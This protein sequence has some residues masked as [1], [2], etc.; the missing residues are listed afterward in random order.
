[1]AK[2]LDDALI[3]WEMNGE[4]LPADHG[5]PARLVVPGWVGIASIKWLGE[6]RVTTTRMRP[7][8][9]RKNGIPY[10]GNATMNEYFVR[11]VDDEGQQYLAVT[12]M[13]DDP[14]YFLQPIVRTMLFK[15]QPDAT[16]WNPTPCVA[17]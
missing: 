12:Q 10:S 6:L 4:P 11:I 8:Y 7:G 5:F 16:G 9:L 15:K 1:M 14:Q 2:A 3:A 17:G 13:L